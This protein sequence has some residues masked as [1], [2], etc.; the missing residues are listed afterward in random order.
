MKYLFF[1]LFFL[2]FILRNFQRFFNSNKNCY[3]NVTGN[4]LLLTAHP[5]DESMFFAPTL[6]NLKG[7]IKI[8]CLSKG[9]TQLSNLSQLACFK[10]EEEMK[11]LCKKFNFELMMYDFLDNDNWDEN[12]ISDILQYIYLTSP[13]KTLITFDN[14]G[15]SNHKNHIS[16]NLGAEIFRK[17]DFLKCKSKIKYWYLKSTNLFD[18][19]LLNIQNDD[20]ILEFKNYF[21]VFSMMKYH[22]SQLLWF[23]YLYLTFSKY[24]SY[25]SYYRK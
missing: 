1:T 7:R 9:N 11:Q 19:Y 2:L 18:K 17:S 23:R 25:N 8:I 4:Y 21:T 6:L 22:W 12:L 14:K 20:F 16:C 5:D 15:V 10:R 13:F 3:N 24:T